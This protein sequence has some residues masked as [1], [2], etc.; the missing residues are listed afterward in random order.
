MTILNG[1]GNGPQVEPQAMFATANMVTPLEEPL[2]RSDRPRVLLVSS[3]TG[4]NRYRTTSYQVVVLNT[5]GTIEAVSSLHTTDDKGGWALRLRDGVAELLQ[6]LSAGPTA[7]EWTAD[8]LMGEMAAVL[9][10]LDAGWT[11]D[12]TE[13]LRMVVT[14][15]ALAV[16]QGEFEATND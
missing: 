7:P 4:S 1:N 14:P 5:D 6:T 11:A 10:R 3:Q 9:V 15:E 12:A 16:A 8:Q 13:M 2:E